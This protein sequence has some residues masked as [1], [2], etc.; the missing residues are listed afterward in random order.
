L[1][2]RKDFGRIKVISGD[3]GGRFPYCNTLYIDDA[4]QTIIDPGAGLHQ[5][6]EI[7]QRKSI[8]LVLNTH[9]HFDHIVYNY[10]FDQARIMVNE[11]EAIYFRDPREFVRA[12]AVAEAL[13]E[14]WI[15]IWPERIRQPNGPQSPY[16][17]FFRHDWHL[18][19]ARLDGTYR[20]GEVF[21]LGHTKMEVIAAPGHS[22]GFS[23]MYFPQEGIVYCGDID[24]TSF[25]PLCQDSDQFIESA[26][27][28]ANL[29]AD[30]FITSH[31]SGVVS[32]S[33]FVSRLDKYLDVLVIR[34]QKLLDN[35]VAPITFEEIVK[36][37]IFYGP[38]IFKDQFLY[39]WEWAMAKEHLRRLIKQGLVVSE[40]G[41]CMRC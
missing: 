7:N 1:D 33:E 2:K 6:Q 27:R 30:I 31:E 4:V 36:M 39:C 18:S 17:P 25:G 21:D 3:N 34:D 37:G 23:V 40:N 20:W 12:S 11:L 24:L 10:V 41:K 8:D 35:L 15:N 29:D 13:G 22:P 26:H 38:R 5:L 16:T 19:L 28:V 14:E 32:K 9:V